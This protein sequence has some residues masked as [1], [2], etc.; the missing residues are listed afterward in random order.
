[1]LPVA[2]HKFSPEFLELPGLDGRAHP[3]HQFQVEMKVVQRDEA[4]AEDFLG[5]HEV[6]QI[7]PLE[8]KAARK[9]PI[10]LDR[11]TIE[12]ILRVL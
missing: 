8:R 9:F 6:P 2:G 10:A 5:F 4:E 7:T 12:A 3:A 1:M 11:F